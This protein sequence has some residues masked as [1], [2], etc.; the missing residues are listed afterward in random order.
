M[1]CNLQKPWLPAESFWLGLIPLAWYPHMRSFISWFII[2]C[3][4]AWIAILFLG[5]SKITKKNKS[6]QRSWWRCVLWTFGDKQECLSPIDAHLVQSLPHKQSPWLISRTLWMEEDTVW[7]LQSFGSNISLSK[8]LLMPL[9]KLWME[10]VTPRA[11]ASSSCFSF[12]I[13]KL[14]SG[15]GFPISIF[16]FVEAEC[17]VCR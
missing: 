7:L 5:I 14:T 17:D 11:K 13:N 6:S 4:F 16:H 2:V 8:P 15:Q 3:H 10:G 1:L 12:C 9:A